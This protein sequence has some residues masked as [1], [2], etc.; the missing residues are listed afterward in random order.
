MYVSRLEPENNA[1]LVIDAYNQLVNDG[2]I[3]PEELPLVIVGDAPYSSDYILDLKR[4]AG[5]GVRF[6]GYVFGEGYLN[7]QLGAKIYI[8]AT[9]VGGTHP[10]LVESMGFANCVIAHKTAENIEVLGDCGYYFEYRSVQSL[11]EILG[12]LVLD[13]QK[14]NES[15]RSAF[16][17]AKQCYS[18]DKVTNDYIKLFENHLK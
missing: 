11:V 13:S 5:D 12:H 18:W 9:E 8:Q 1:H 17:R 16:L 4:R 2:I 7:L 10:A 3:F 6:L 15:R 14:I